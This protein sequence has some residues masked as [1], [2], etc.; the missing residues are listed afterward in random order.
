MKQRASS[1]AFKPYDQHQMSAFPLDL[2]EL[3]SDNHIVRSISQIIDKLDLTQLLAKYPKMGAASYHPRLLVKLLVYGYINNIYSSRQLEEAC[4]RDIH[5][6]W[7]TAMSQPD[8]NTIAR[9]RSNRLTEDGIRPI[10]K[11][12]VLF[13]AEAGELHLKEVY[14]DGTKIES[15]ANKYTFVW[16]RAIKTNKDRML[17]QLDELWEYAS[18]LNKEEL[19]AKPKLSAEGLKPEDIKQ[20][21]NQIN[22]A[23]Q[24]KEVDPKV[25]QKIAYGAK[26]WPESVQK[27]EQQQEQMQ[28]RKSMSKTDPDATFMRM[29]EDHMQNGQLKPGYNLQISTSN[30]YL[31]YLSLHQSPTDT[32]TLIPHLNGYNQLYGQMPEA[33]T[34]DAG[35]GSNENYSF[36][37]QQQITPFIKYNYFHK[38]QS[39][40]WSTDPFKVQNLVFDQINNCFYCPAGKPLQWTGDK[41]QT[42]DNGF[43]KKIDIYEAESCKG[44]ELRK[45]CFKGTH[46]RRIEVNHE[47]RRQKEMAKQLLNS[48]EGIKHR[49]K[50]PADVEAVFGQIKY[51][52]NYKRFRLSGLSKNVVDLNIVAIAHNLKKYLKRKKDYKNAA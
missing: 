26:R 5:F 18:H 37:E 35:Y 24:G 42:S 44:C 32:T 38:E 12:V 9:F 31:I 22:E 45:N 41:I 46:N 8:H 6:L 19:Q 43:Q 27:Y 52:N 15:K 51:N 11:Q 36:C 3:I 20:A 30:Q 33:V 34:A 28:D 16:E 50:R 4:K 21:I 39:K 48:P 23:I 14:T 49:K 13:L 7:L 29:K 2:N 17:K 1:R 47:L 40:K 10:F 25:K